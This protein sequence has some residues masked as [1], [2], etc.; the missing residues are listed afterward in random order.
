MSRQHVL[1]LDSCPGAACPR[2]VAGV[3]EAGRGPLA[4][5]VVA[6]AVIIHPARPLQ[7]VADS[8]VLSHARREELADMIRA[9]AWAWSVA[10]IDID[11]IDRLNILQASMLAMQRAVLRLPIAPARALVDGNMLPR[12]LPCPAQALVG[13]DALEPAISAASILA[14]TWRDAIMR[15]LDGT[16]PQYGF[17]QHKGYATPAHRAALLEHGPCAIHRRSFAPVR[18]LLAGLDAAG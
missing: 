10:V 2:P 3:D 12:A 15:K 9:R 8:K 16:Y 18:E 6:A 5:P 1:A 17:A 14:K 13:G 4:G 11:D 7:D